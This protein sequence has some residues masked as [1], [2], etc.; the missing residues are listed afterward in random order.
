MDILR[1]PSDHHFLPDFTRRLHEWRLADGS[2]S[3]WN[4]LLGAARL[5]DAG[6]SVDFVRARLAAEPPH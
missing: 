5:T 1:R 2:E 6:R 3:Y 4:R